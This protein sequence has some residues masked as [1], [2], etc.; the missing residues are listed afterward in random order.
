MKRD[1]TNGREQQIG[2]G[3]SVMQTKLQRDLGMDLAMARLERRGVN[4]YNTSGG[5]ADLG[6]W[7]RIGKR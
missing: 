5:L 3:I 2:Y 7:S 6:H 4:P 1:Y